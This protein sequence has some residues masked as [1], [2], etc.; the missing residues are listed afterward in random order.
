M[1]NKLKKS[2]RERE[3]QHTRQG[4]PEDVRVNQDPGVEAVTMGV[5][6][7]PQAWDVLFEAKV[8]S[9]FG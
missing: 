5:V 6:R 7:S 8:D 1:K 3:R 9:T 2:R 4:A